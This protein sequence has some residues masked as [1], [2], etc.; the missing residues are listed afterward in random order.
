MNE[1]TL[2]KADVDSLLAVDPRIRFVQLC[3]REGRIRLEAKREKVDDLDSEESTKLILT[4][5]AI[6]N[7][8]AHSHDTRH[9]AVRMVIIQR[10]RLMMVQFAIFEGFV[11]VSAEPDLPLERAAEL[12]RKLDLAGCE[13][14]S[15][16]GAA[17]AP[18]GAQRWMAGD[19][20]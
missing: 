11:L 8:M 18:R 6:G 5:A 10:E 1:F 17:M 7:G 12:G 14:A 3:D 2:S 4:Q 15:T 13:P 20:R 16:A 19:L 9:G